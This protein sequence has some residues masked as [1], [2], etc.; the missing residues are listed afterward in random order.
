MQ[1][2]NLLNTQE[3]LS[4]VSEGNFS[5]QEP[6]I[7]Y[8]EP[9]VKFV[10]QTLKYA[11]DTRASDVHIEPFESHCRIRLRQDGILKTVSEIPI[12]LFNRFATRL[13]VL[14]KLNIAEKRLPQDGRFQFTIEDKK[15]DV[16][17]S[18]C[19][20]LFG[21]KIV[22]RL[23]NTHFMLLEIDNLGFTASQK[24]IFT[25]KISQ[26][27]GL[28]LV[29]GPTGC[30]KT[31]TLYSALQH[32]NS[33]NK[34]ISTVENPVEIE[35]PGINQVNIQPKIDLTFENV[36]RAFLRQDPDVIM[37]GEIRDKETANIALQAAQ[38]GHL[39]F[40]TL[41]ANNTYEAFVRLHSMGLPLYDVANAITLVIA[42][43]LV[44]KRA[45]TAYAGRTG[46]FEFLP[47]TTALRERIKQDLSLPAFTQF[48]QENNLATLRVSA[49]LLVKNR[50]TD[51]AEIQ[52]VLSV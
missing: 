17:I 19:P 24:R 42:Q 8:D 4:L 36:L 52:R 50:V 46:I 31:V 51:E 20:T 22:L 49:D 32:L 43:R 3:L 5:V 13:K 18:I 38:T 40:S 10:N 34:N 9:V 44:R 16:R 45:D 1:H 21:E 27:Q 29:T 15:I 2:R 37:L 41:H 47:V 12:V 6:V 25:Q 30:G 14:A 33:E 28:I 7:E 23:L 26:P 48:M 35:M 11:L 39:V